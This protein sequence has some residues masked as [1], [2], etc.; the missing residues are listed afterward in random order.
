MPNFWVQHVFPIW[1]RSELRKLRIK[2]SKL[3]PSK[4]MAIN[5]R[6]GLRTCT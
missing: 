4:E 3:I 2:D 6:C 1:K 5:L